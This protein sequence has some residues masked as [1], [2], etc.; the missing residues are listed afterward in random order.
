[1]NYDEQLYEK[2][3]TELDHFKSK[4]NE[5]NDK[6]NILR[7]RICD[8]TRDDFDTEWET[9]IQHLRQKRIDL[10]AENRKITAEIIGKKVVHHVLTDLRKDED[11]KI[12]QGLKSEMILDPL[13]RITQR[14]KGLEL[15]DDKLIVYDDYDHF[16]LADL[17]TGAQEQIFLALRIGFVQKLVKSREPL[18]LILDDAFQYSDWERRVWLMDMM[19]DLA[20]AG[21]QILYISLKTDT[22][23]WLLVK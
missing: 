13:Q 9:L 17:S 22:C 23:C 6:L 11:S 2:I 14:Y 19:V 8:Q 1:M 3:Q 21:W 10:I 4:I 12:I 16:D 7:N 15:Q 20:K 5:E 18:F